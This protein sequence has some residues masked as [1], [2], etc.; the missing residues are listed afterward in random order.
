MYSSSTVSKS[1]HNYLSDIN[2]LNIFISGNVEEVFY[3]D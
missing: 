1:K 2:K 3:G